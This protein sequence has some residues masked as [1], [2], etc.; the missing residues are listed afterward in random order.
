MIYFMNHSYIK[1]IA[2][3]ISIIFAGMLSVGVIIFEPISGNTIRSEVDE[4]LEQAGEKMDQADEPAAL[5]IY[6]EVLEI[7]PDNF[8]ALWNLSLLYSKKGH[9]YEDKDEMRYY[10][11]RGKSLAEKALDYYPDEA[12]AHYVYAVAIARIADI[13]NPS[14]RIRA[15][16]IIREHTERAIEIDSEHHGA[17]HLLGVWHT[18][19]ANLSRTERWAANL[20]FGGAPEGASNEEAEKCLL[21]AIELDPD[22][23]LFHLDLSRFY[24]T[25]NRNEEAVEVLNRTVALEPQEMDD[26]DM[27][28]EAREMLR[29]LR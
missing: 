15:S 10:Y 24:I 6:E 13:E 19:S 25:T 29:D 27:L 23:I 21:R 17:W 2:K 1:N 8:E 26:P 12:Y 22:N 14:D 3:L 28:Q 18:R 4:L 7:E 9:R 20:L 16:E 11:E 5:V